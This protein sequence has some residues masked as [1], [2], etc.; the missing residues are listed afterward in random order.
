M[1][2][3]SHFIQNIAR[4]KKQRY[5]N[6]IL[7]SM[8]STLTMNMFAKRKFGRGFE[9]PAAR[10]RIG[11]RS[12]TPTGFSR[13]GAEISSESIPKS[14]SIPV[15]K[16]NCGVGC[17]LRHLMSRKTSIFFSMVSIGLISMVISPDRLIFRAVYVITLNSTA[18]RVL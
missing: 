17:Q 5:R 2:P 15:S 4:I 9:I 3:I 11:L 8:V 10:P 16:P 7:Q 13:K 1:K 14:A 18:E 6:R 12:T